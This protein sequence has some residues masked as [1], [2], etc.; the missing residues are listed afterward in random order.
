MGLNCSAFGSPLRSLSRLVLSA[1]WLTS[2]LPCKG[3]LYLAELFSA[4]GVGVVGIRGLVGSLLSGGSGSLSSGSSFSSP[5]PSGPNSVFV[6]DLM[7]ALVGRSVLSSLGLG[8]SCFSS[9][10]FPF[11]D[12][13]SLDSEFLTIFSP[14]WANENVA[15]IPEIPLVDVA[16]GPCIVFSVF[17][18]PESEFSLDSSTCID[19]LGQFTCGLVFSNGSHA[20]ERFCVQAK[21]LIAEEIPDLDIDELS[22][23]LSE[24]VSFFSVIGS[25]LINLK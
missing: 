2:G 3:I 8:S 10:M 4:T 19:F 11:L 9:C 7:G 18:G 16:G 20:V 14:S 21:S 22:D 17:F 15:K 12:V 24:V 1:S 23:I 6:V 13:S 5:C 25:S